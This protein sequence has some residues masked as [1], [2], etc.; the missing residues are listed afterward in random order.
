MAFAVRQDK[1]LF[2]PGPLTTSATVKAAMLHDAG[3]RDAAFL[4]VVREIRERLLGIAGA[5]TGGDYECVLM[6]GSGTFAIESVISSVIPPDGRLLVLVNGAYGRRIAQIARVHRLEVEVLESPE[7]CKIAPEEVAARLAD[8]PPVTHAAV[9][10]CETTTGILNPIE[11]IG[12]AVA[13]S[14]GQYIVDAMSSFGG[15]P[16]HV[17]AA[18]ADFLISS[19]NKCIEGVPGFGFVLARRGPLMAARGQARTVS[20]D[21]HA[22]WAGLEADGQFRFTPPTHALLAFHQALLELEAEGGVVG[23]ADRYRANHQALARGMAALGF[24]AYL[25]P[26]DQSHIITT[27]RYPAD[28]G[29]RFDEFY[30]RL[31][32]MGL[33][34]YPGKLSQEPCFRI[35]TIGR[36]DVR[37]IQRLLDAIADIRSTVAAK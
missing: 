23:R 18:H 31:N 15:I 10:H 34:I 6:Q 7:S 5:H 16:I 33:I 32:E 22:Q 27:Y 25:A 19:A 20:L 14:G 17:E 4:A 37:D 30:E 21:L 11:E 29:F 12:A 26:E 36:L 9:V 2:T 24:E 13:Q 3:S 35:G 1:L 8:A 28:P